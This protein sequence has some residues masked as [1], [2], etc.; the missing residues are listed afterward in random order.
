M[1]AFVLREENNKLHNNNAVSD[2]K[3]QPNTSEGD[4]K[5]LGKEAEAL[6]SNHDNLRND[7]NQLRSDTVPAMHSSSPMTTFKVVPMS[8]LLRGR[9]HS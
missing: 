8:T 6:R 7:H 1:E 9:A 3:A 2:L 4:Y 5:R